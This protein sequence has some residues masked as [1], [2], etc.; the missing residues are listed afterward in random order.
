MNGINR[1][2]QYVFWLPGNFTV[3]KRCQEDTKT[4]INTKYVKFELMSLGHIGNVN[5]TSKRTG[6]VCNLSSTFLVKLGAEDY[7]STKVHFMCDKITLSPLAFWSFLLLGHVMLNLGFIFYS[8]T[9]VIKLKKCKF[10]LQCIFM[11]QLF[12]LV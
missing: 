6:S 7:T 9:S 11:R 3:K 2:A 4:F 1:T 8:G 10:T 5:S 12:W